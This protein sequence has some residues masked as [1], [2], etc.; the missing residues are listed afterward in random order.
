MCSWN[1]KNVWTVKHW[2]WIQPQ[3]TNLYCL[4]FSFLFCLCVCCI[5]QQSTY[6]CC[7]SIVQ[8]FVYNKSAMQF[9]S[10]STDAN[11]ILR[12]MNFYL[13]WMAFKLSYTYLSK[14]QIG[15]YTLRRVE[16]CIYSRSK[17]FC[18]GVCAVRILHSQHAPNKSSDARRLFVCKPKCHSYYV[19]RLFVMYTTWFYCIIS[20]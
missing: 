5:C 14:Q 10:E 11:Y 19:N 12:R 9:R 13:T 2:H 17:Q 16:N 6:C 3:R 18:S 15:I 7:C 4:L 1:E 8:A 20:Y